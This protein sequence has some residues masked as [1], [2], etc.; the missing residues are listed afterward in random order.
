[1]VAR[2]KENGSIQYLLKTKLAIM[3][4]VGGLLQKLSIKERK[5]HSINQ[6][7]QAFLYYSAPEEDILVN[8]FSVQMSKA[9][10]FLF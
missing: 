5:V 3:T 1:M 8:K 4:W 2:N 6:A 7:T 10:F 9:N